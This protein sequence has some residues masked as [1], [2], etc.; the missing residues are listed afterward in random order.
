MCW[1]FPLDASAVY[2]AAGL[3]R[4]ED[5]FNAKDLAAFQARVLG[6]KTPSARYKWVA[7]YEGSRYLSTAAMPVCSCHKL[8]QDG[9]KAVSDWAVPVAWHLSVAVRNPERKQCLDEYSCVAGFM[10]SPRRRVQAEPRNVL[11]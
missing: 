1:Q 11:Q 3:A 4:G 6:V 10:P 9:L 8:R 7:A 2:H 5:L